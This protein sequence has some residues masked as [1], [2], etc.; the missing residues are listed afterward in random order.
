MRSAINR[1]REMRIAV[2]ATSALRDETSFVGLG[3]TVEPL[4]VFVVV[5]NCTD[6]NLDFEILPI[7]AMTIAAFAVPTTFSAERV[8]VSKLQKRFFVD[9]CYEIDIAAT[10]A[11]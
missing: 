7:T 4:A 1:R 9:I 11:I 5:D 6:G 10:T 2:A 8:V 3:E